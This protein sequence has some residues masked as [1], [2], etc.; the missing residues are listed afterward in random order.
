MPMPEPTPPPTT[1]RDLTR[2]TLGV[3][4]IGV[5]IVASLWVLRPFIAPTIW[6]LMIVVSTWP[7]L[8]WFQARLWGRRSS[9]GGGD[10]AADRAAAGG[11][12]DGGHRHHR[13][14]CRRHRR[15][16][17]DP[18]G[19]RAVAAAAL[20]GDAAAGRREAG[21]AVGAGRGAGS[22]GL[23]AQVAPYADD[24]A[25]WFVAQAGS[26]GLVFVQFFITVVLAAVMYAGGET[27]RLGRAALRPSPGRG[28]WRGRGA[29]GG[30]GDP[31]RGAWRRRHRAWCSRGWA[32]S[33][34]RSSA[35]LSPGC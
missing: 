2:T 17:G 13:A 10:D 34:W 11:A 27:R 20:G 22:K 21:A 9:G 32:A 29:A 26:L 30:P 19:L 33:A 6:A 3:L 15:A 4:F 18:V 14:P 12:A 31:R 5:L 1:P 28:L 16:G 25:K 23:L 24:I 8:R 35:C 7:M